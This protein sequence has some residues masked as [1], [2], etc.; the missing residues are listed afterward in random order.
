MVSRGFVLGLTE[1]LGIAV[2]GCSHSTAL[3]WVPLCTAVYF[4]LRQKAW[5]LPKGPEKP[6]RLVIQGL[7]FVLRLSLIH[8]LARA[9]SP[10]L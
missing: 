2:L 5:M 7:L 6:I 4:C 8:G 10:T 1:G 3:L 9:F